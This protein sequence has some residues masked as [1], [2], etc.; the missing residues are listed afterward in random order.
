[1][2]IITL[3]ITD[4]DGDKIIVMSFDIIAHLHVSTIKYD[5][6]FMTVNTSMTL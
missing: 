2:Q 3:V 4:I 5:S 1:M 6:M